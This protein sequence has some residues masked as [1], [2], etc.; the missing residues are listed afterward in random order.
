MSDDRQLKSRIEAALTRDTRVNVPQSTLDIVVQG[1]Y[2]TLSGTVPTVAAKRLCHRLAAAVEG[3]KAVEDRTRVETGETMGDLELL[4]H[5]RRSLVEE[6]NIEENQIVLEAEE[7]GGVLL[8][9]E[10]HSLVQ[11]RL[12]EVLAWWVPGVRN[13]TNLIVVDPPEEDNDEELRD[14]LQVIFAKDFLVDPARFKVLVHDGIVTL[15]GQVPAEEEKRAA[16]KD[17]WYTPG[18]VDVVNELEVG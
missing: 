16:E 3:V 7:E 10:V 12:A 1:G 5:L 9:G 14:N 4:D 15:R 2:V 18:V 6:R 11:R 13:V 8:R 17:C